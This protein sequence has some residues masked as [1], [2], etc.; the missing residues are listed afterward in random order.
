MGGRI[1]ALD[2]GTRSVTG[3]LIE[4]QDNNFAVIDYY[5]KEHEERS[6]RDGQIHNVIAV[7]EVIR[8]VKEKLE[9]EHGQLHQVSVAAAGR[10][11]KTCQAEATL[12]LDQHPITDSGTIKHLELSAVQAAQLKLAAMDNNNEYTNY[13]CVGYSVLEYKLDDAQIGS[14]IDQS[15][16]QATAEIIATFLPK[17]VVES[18]LAALGRANLEMEA[19]TLE[20]IAA[21]HVL[22]PESMR[23]LNVALVDIGAGTSDIAIT[24]KGTVVAY[25]MVPVAGD[26]ITEEIS[27]QYLLDF[28]MAEQ[29]KKSI[30]RS[31]QDTVQDILGFETTITYE[32][33]VEDIKK[34]VEKVADSIS[35]EILKLNSK[36]PKAVM[37]V[38]GGSLTPNITTAL[39][40]RLQLPE[41][42]V[43]KRGIDAIQNLVKTEKLPPGPDFV[44][45]VGIAIAAKQNPVHYISVAVNEQTIRMFEMKQLTI[46]DCLVQ[47]GLDIKKLY[48][49][50]GI[51][52]IVTVDGKEITL[53][54]GY[55]QPPVIILNDFEA[56]VDDVIQ[57]GDKIII[58]K[59]NDGKEPHITIEELMGEGT[60]LFINF[61]NRSHKLET[62][63]SVNGQLKPKSYLIQDND[64][65]IIR[66]LHTIEDFLVSESTEK[67][68]YT[69]PFSIF[70]NNRKVTI[71]KGESHIY[72]NNKKVNRTHPLKQNDHLT[73]ITAQHPMVQD[74]LP[75]LDKEFWNTI[76]VTFNGKSV[77]IKQQ[78]VSVLRNQLELGPDT[79]LYFN[80]EL[81]IKD[82]KQETFIFQ[83]VFRYIDVDMTNASGHFQLY[84]NN[85]PTTFYESIQ[86]G[87]KLQIVWGKKKS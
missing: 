83:D 28:P 70:V 2:I 34:S 8:D 18:L 40:N 23:R 11:L 75:Q 22:I 55:G 53:P 1:F 38:G 32:T 43:A 58:S 49:K 16:D 66:Q 42:R 27:D 46:G 36:S 50:P 64:E 33:L 62:T 10:A 61:N 17:V 39:A 68:Q 9:A 65:I 35:T 19:L 69:Q 48:G 84:N 13:Y 47:A 31:G 37:L 54:G 74:V 78:Q 73:I 24:D 14:L 51:A 44:T 41:N 80:D 63:F 86:H 25:G 45:P 59:G 15:G 6:M 7:S 21:I 12:K 20:P 52:S 29:T 79:E 26:E 81:Q 3:I 82:R 76:N 71:D 57:N 4:K 67:L 60:S 87:D 56:T 30:I 72:L 5:M 77:L 85:Q